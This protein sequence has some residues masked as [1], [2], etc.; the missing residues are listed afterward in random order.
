[1][2]VFSSDERVMTDVFHFIRGTRLDPK[3]LDVSTEDV[4]R[5]MYRRRLC[6]KDRQWDSTV[7]GMFASEVP[8]ECSMF[9][10]SK[11][12]TWRP[13]AS[14]TSARKIMFLDASRVQR[15][16]LKVGCRVHEDLS[17]AELRFYAEV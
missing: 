6:W 3:L 14:G 13:G 1:M 15:Q 16:Q 5:S 12:I 11:A 7:L 2:I 9:L 10:C 17:V 8:F 4:K